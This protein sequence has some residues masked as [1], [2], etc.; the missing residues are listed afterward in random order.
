MFC[1]FL[2]PLIEAQKKK[3]HYVCV[4]ASDDPDAEQIRKEDIDVFYHGQRRSVNPFNILKPVFK[5]RKILIE[6]KIDLLICHAPLGAAVGRIAGWLAKTPH[7]IYFVHGMPCVPSQNPLVYYFWFGLEKLLGLMTNALILMN[8]YDE[9]LCK[10]RRI[11]RN[12]NKIFRIPGMGVDLEKFKPTTGEEERRRL[13]EELGIAKDKKI[14][15]CVAWLIPRK[16]IFYYLEA[17]RE[18]CARRKDVCFLLAGNGPFMDK[19]K[20]SC[21]KYGLEGNFKILGWRNDINQLMNASDVF[22]LPSYYWEGLPVSILEAMACGKPVIATQQRGCEDAVLDRQTGFL[23]PVK[24]IPPLVDKIQLLLDND[25]LRVRMG[26]AGRLR[27][28]SNYELNYC[29]H[30][31]VEFIEAAVR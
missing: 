10:S 25:Q 28:E 19:L 3:G 24:Q 6:Q 18:I 5:I 12:P 29:L 23:V 20:K 22:V 2:F 11:I 8:S 9:H 14:V 26:Q 13:A 17:A 30:T 27:I 31:I 1:Q 4:C 21:I 16:G 15:L 7:I